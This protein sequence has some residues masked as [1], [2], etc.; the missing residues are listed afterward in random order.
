MNGRS[1]HR[2][3]YSVAEAAELLGIGRSTAYEL[4]ARGDLPVARLGSRI[5]ITRPTLTGLLGVEPPLPIELDVSDSPQAAKATTSPDASPQ[6]GPSS[7]RP[8]RQDRLPFPPGNA[9]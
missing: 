3:V 6:A 2:L 7:D 9:R 5:V 4:V 8:D 1:R